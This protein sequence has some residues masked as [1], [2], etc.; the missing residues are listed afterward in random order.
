[1]KAQKMTGLQQLAAELNATGGIQTSA[2]VQ[3]I[4]DDVIL[5]NSANLSCFCSA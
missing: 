3:Q 1:M 5:G 4:A 2:Y